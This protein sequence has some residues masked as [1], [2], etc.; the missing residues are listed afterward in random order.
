MTADDDGDDG[1]DEDEAEEDGEDVAGM[2][3]DVDE[4]RAGIE[5]MEIIGPCTIEEELDAILARPSKRE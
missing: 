2:D 4:A 1:T 5:N 3:V